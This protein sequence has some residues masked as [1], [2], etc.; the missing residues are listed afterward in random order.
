MMFEKLNMKEQVGLFMEL[1][2]GIDYVCKYDQ[3]LC[4]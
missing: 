3:N 1:K 4:P 2:V